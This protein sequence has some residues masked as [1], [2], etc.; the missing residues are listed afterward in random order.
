MVCQ[1]YRGK[2]CRGR[3]S[4]T[5]APSIDRSWMVCQ[6]YRGFKYIQGQQQQ[7]GNGKQGFRV[8]RGQNGYKKQGQQHQ[9]KTGTQGLPGG[10]AWI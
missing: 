7:D 6:I 4:E 10:R 1:T 5:G 9:E 8:S 3:E 2:S